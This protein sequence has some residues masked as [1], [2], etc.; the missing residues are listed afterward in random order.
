MISFGIKIRKGPKLEGCAFV[1]FGNSSGT[2][3]DPSKK[4]E[5]NGRKKKKINAASTGV[6]KSRNLRISEEPKEL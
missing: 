3:R 5:K 6:R 2:E 4:R 1:N